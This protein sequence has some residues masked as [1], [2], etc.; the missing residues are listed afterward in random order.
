[1]SNI[2]ELFN[3]Y[4]YHILIILIIIL[5]WRILQ[6]NLFLIF[7]IAILGYIIYKENYKDNSEKSQINLPPVNLATHSP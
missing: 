7:I 6:E 1:M 5:L 4:K 3:K 2:N